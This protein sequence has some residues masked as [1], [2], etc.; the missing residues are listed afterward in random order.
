MPKKL[1]PYGSAEDAE[2]AALGRNR[3]ETRGEQLS[4]LASTMTVREIAI[5]AAEAIRALNDLTADRAELSG[6]DD[7][8]AVIASLELMGHGLPRLCEQLARVLVAL[9]E[10]GEIANG[11]GQ[12][13][14]FTV[15]AATEALTAAGQAA[16][17]MTAALDEAYQKSATLNAAQ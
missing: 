8:R 4:E 13:A 6:P 9:R 10:D 3:P 1:R 12:D 7:V 15:A 16:D 2:L 11:A 17:M 5:G 14:D